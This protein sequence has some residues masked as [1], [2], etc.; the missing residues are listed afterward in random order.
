MSAETPSIKD[1]YEISQ[2]VEDKFDTRFEDVP[3]RREM[4]LWIGVAL[5]GG[6]VVASLV[7]AAITS[8]SPAQQVHV[9][10]QF[11]FHIL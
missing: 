8:M 2:R 6:Q 11:V 3:T 4:K 1:I 10:A 5:L 9:A 7:T